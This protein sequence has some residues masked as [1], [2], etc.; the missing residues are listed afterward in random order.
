MI[1]KLVAAV[2]VPLQNDDIAL[3]ERVFETLAAQHGM[4]EDEREQLASSILHFY[5]D[6]VKDERSLTRLLMK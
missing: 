3:C 6:G 5:Q 4:S 2:K 1:R